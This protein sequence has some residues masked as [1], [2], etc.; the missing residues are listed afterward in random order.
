MTKSPA[1][2]NPLRLLRESLSADGSSAPISQTALSRITA[3][4]LDSIRSIESRRRSLTPAIQQQILRACGARWDEAAGQWLFRHGPKGP[5]PFEYAD[6]EAYRSFYEAPIKAPELDIGVI[7][8]MLQKLVGA[9]K[10]P[11][12]FHQLIDR[13]HESFEEWQKE[14]KLPPDFF[15]EYWPALVVQ[16]DA[17][18]GELISVSRQ[19]PAKITKLVHSKLERAIDR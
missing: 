2:A 13:I 10:N 9:V 16:S 8:L 4:G 6:Y 18:T 5:K 14:F 17:G 1:P 3:I 15:S 11:A 12:R 19:Y 7:T